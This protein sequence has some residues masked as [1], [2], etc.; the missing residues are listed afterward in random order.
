MQDGIIWVTEPEPPFYVRVSA[1]LPNGFTL[2]EVGPSEDL[3]VKKIMKQLNILEE[4]Y[5]CERRAS[6]GRHDAEPGYD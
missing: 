1:T 5:E 4:F 3:L 2:T 6:A